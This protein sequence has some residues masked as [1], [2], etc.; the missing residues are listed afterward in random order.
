M[1]SSP[2]QATEVHQYA[3]D[4]SPGKPR[5]CRVGGMRIT[6]LTVGLPFAFVVVVC[7][8]LLVALR[9]WQGRE[10]KTRAETGT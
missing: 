7:L 10:G 1:R 5:G 3:R 4:V 8:V 2:A 6:A 9:P